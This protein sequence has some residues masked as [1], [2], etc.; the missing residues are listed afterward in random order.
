MCLG[1]CLNLL[2]P[3]LENGHFGQVGKWGVLVDLVDWRM[4]LKVVDY[5]MMMMMIA[6]A[7]EG[8]LNH[9][10]VMKP[11]SLVQNLTVGMDGAKSWP[12]EI[13]QRMTWRSLD[14]EWMVRTLTVWKLV[15]GPIWRKAWNVW[16]M[17]LS[18][19]NLRADFQRGEVLSRDFGNMNDEWMMRSH[20]VWRPILKCVRMKFDEIWAGFFTIDRFHA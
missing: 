17:V 20:T 1:T 11:P 4:I 13:F 12:F 2:S 3:S 7:S 10:W 8:H 5:E 18:L 6:R 14:C 16:S 15:L 19:D 9:V